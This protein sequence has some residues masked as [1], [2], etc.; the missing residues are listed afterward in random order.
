MV[1]LKY[2]EKAEKHQ[3]YNLATVI[4]RFEQVD[5]DSFVEHAE[6]ALETLVDDVLSLSQ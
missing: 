6:E 2:K 5:V 3:L 1:W 4:L